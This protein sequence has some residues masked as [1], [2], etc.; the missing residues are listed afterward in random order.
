M[1]EETT[2]TTTEPILAQLTKRIDDQAR[3]TRTAV[4]VCTV[5]ILGTM[6]WMITEIYGSL[7]SLIVGTFMQQMET[8]RDHWYLLEHRKPRPEESKAPAKS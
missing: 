7:P 4:V 2:T 8:I 1:A 6:F 5:A 3:F